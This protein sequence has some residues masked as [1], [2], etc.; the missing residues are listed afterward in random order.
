MRKV[1]SPQDVAHLFANQ[2]QEEARTPTG[3]L[4]FYGQKI[5]SYGSHFCIAR[6]VDDRTLLF[7][8]RSY[9][10]TT[11]KHINYVWGATSH[12]DRILCA[13]PTGSHE[14]N[15]NYWINEAE[16]ITD[17]LRNARKPEIYLTELNNLKYRVD[18]YKQYFK[19]DMPITLEKVLSITNK[20]EVV[21]YLASKQKL[22]DAEAKRK[23]KEHAKLHAE[24]LKKWRS[25][26]K[27]SLY[28]RDDYDYIRKDDENFQTSQGVKIPIEIGLRLYR[29]IRNLSQGDK[30][31]D[32]TVGEVTKNY[33][34]I[35]CHKITFKEIDNIIK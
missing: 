20:A 10:N 13:Y 14:Q 28:L 8:E 3:N 12:K 31:L 9:S 26:E 19:I 18:R 27:Q 24:E 34:R 23:A 30:F 2:L 4:Y 5:Y 22:I 33:I 17:K 16:A 15:F 21:D 32:Y 1:V 35:G 25:F 6:F 29:N 7:T 11:A